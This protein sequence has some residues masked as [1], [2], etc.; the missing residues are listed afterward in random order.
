MGTLL[1]CYEY[2]LYIHAHLLG[3][4]PIVVGLK[5]DGSVPGKPRNDGIMGIFSIL[6]DN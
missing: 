6:W 4:T 5:T 2:L 1:Q 3:A